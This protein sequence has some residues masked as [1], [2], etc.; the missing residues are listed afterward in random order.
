[1]NKQDKID[2]IYEKI[3]DKTLSFWCSIFIQNYITSVVI[4]WDNRWFTL[5]EWTEY[6]DFLWQTWTSTQT[7]KEK[8]IKK[9]IWHPVF[10]WVLLEYHDKECDWY[11]MNSWEVFEL[12]ELWK[13]KKLPIEEQS[14]DC[15]DYVYNLIK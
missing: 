8:H 11:L 13:N 2:T 9:I 14:D 1:M 4:I 5:V 3:S 10:I 6:T 12:F 7:F 15:I